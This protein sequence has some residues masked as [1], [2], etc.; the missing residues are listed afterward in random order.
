MIFFIATPHRIRP[1]FGFA[2]ARY[3]MQMYI[4]QGKCLQ[5]ASPIALHNVDALFCVETGS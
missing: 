5:P 3:K 4:N 2:R 1:F